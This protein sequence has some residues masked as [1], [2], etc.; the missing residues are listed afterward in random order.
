MFKAQVKLS[1]GQLVWVDIVSA[2]SLSEARAMA[3]AYG[4][5]IIVY[6]NA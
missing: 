1:G 2:R 5:V 4:Q 6:S 3:E